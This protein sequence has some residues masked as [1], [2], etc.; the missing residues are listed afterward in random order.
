MRM[1]SEVSALVHL[2]AIERS[3]SENFMHTRHIP[4]GDTHVS[5]EKI[6]CIAIWG[7]IILVHFSAKSQK[8]LHKCLENTQEQCPCLYL[9]AEPGAPPLEPPP[10]QEAA[11]R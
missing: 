10:L 3:A 7:D 9:L 1:C 11:A 8:S 4:K 5:Y 2:E 6:A